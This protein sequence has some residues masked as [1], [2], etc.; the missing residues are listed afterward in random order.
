MSLIKRIKEHTKKSYQARIT[1]T[2]KPHNNVCNYGLEVGDICI[3]WGEGE[4]KNFSV[5]ALERI[6]PLLTDWRVS[7]AVKFLEKGDVQECLSVLNIKEEAIKY[8]IGIMYE[9][10]RTWLTKNEIEYPKTYDDLAIPVKDAKLQRW[11]LNKR[12]EPIMGKIKVVNIGVTNKGNSVVP[13]EWMG[14]EFESAKELHSEMDKLPWRKGKPE[15]H[16]CCVHSMT[17]KE[18]EKWISSKDAKKIKTGVDLYINMTHQPTIKAKPTIIDGYSYIKIT[19]KPGTKVLIGIQLKQ[20]FNTKPAYE[21]TENIGILVSRLQKAI[22]RGSGCSTVLA[23]SIKQLAIA[24]PYNL[25]N[26]QFIRVSGSRQLAWRLFISIVEDGNVYLPTKDTLSMLQLS[27][28]SLLCNTDPELQLNSTTVDKMTITALRVQEYG[29]IFPWRTGSSTAKVTLTDKPLLDAFYLAI[30]TMPMMKNDRRMLIKGYDVINKGHKPFKQS[31]HKVQQMIDKNDNDITRKC[32]LA[33]NDMH[34]LPGM[35]IQLQACLKPSMVTK[36]ISGFIWNNSSRLNYRLPKETANGDPLLIKELERIQE[37]YLMQQTHKPFK[38][39]KLDKAKLKVKRKVSKLVGRIAFL[40]LFGLKQNVTTAK[41]KNLEIVVSGTEDDPI[42]VKKPSAQK[43]VFLEGKEKQKGIDIYLNTTYNI[44]LPKPPSGF[45]WWTKKKDVKIRCIKKEGYMFF[46][47]NLPLKPF[48]GSSLLKA[49]SYPKPVVPNKEVKDILDKAIFLKKESNQWSF[50]NRLLLTNLSQLINWSPVVKKASLGPIWQHVRAKIFNSFN[51]IVQIGPVDRTGNK[52]N[53]SISYLYEGCIYRMFHLL[54]FLYP[55]VVRR[56]GLY[57]FVINTSCAEY[58]HLIGSLNELCKSDKVIKM[59]KPPIL[60]TKLWD[61]QKSS[62]LMMS[63]GILDLGQRGFGDAS[64]VGSGKTLTALQTVCHLLAYNYKQDTKTHQGILVLV[65]NKRLIKTW[66]DEIDKHTK[67]FRYVLQEANGKLSD[68]IGTNSILITTLG[69]M[70]DHPIANP[71]TITIIDECLSVQNKEAL[72]TEEAWRQVLNSKYGV[73]MMSATFF[74]SR[75]NKL[76]YM[77]KMLRSGLPENKEFLDTILSECMICNIPENSRKWIT[78]TV[79]YELDRK[80]RKEYEHIRRGRGGAEDLYTKLSKL[81]FNKVDYVDI[82][83][84]A[85]K[86]MKGKVLI[87]CRSVEEAVELAEREK[88]VTKYPDKSG[89]HCVVTYQ[90]GS[91]GLNDLVGYGSILTRPPQPDLLPQMKGRLDRPG[92]PS[93]ILKIQYV[94]LK[95]T[96]E[97]AW[98]LRLEMASTFFRHHIMPLA[99][100]YQLAVN[101]S[102]N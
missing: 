52:V 26:Q 13:E 83:I 1:D 21:S 77:L 98:L 63:Q 82:F 22:R 89:K 31:K 7:R 42:K 80:I 94:L 33:A 70:R 18:I 44:R 56:R 54:Q 8:G 49:K 9:V 28:L 65:P 55:M 25:A 3:R 38:I 95:D 19:T 32:L 53:E 99:E 11:I 51:D 81:I 4:Y 75:F 5:M 34:C 59:I 20:Y 69:R 78:E 12:S 76:F 92:Q 88:T 60:K 40:L 15:V 64:N 93:D 72:Q 84:Q 68:M 74:R 66:T 79:R 6:K 48:D 43:T 96:I 57:R 101:L 46:V 37:H 90:E 10:L 50:L 39:G 97:E 36:E 16:Y 73:I 87:Y 58:N 30:Q 2:G 91:Y 41:G 29:K 27:I 24:K 85:L 35:I 61:H 45:E 71:W 47:D 86:K 14:R 62:S 100:F 67:G 17:I 102:K 23:D